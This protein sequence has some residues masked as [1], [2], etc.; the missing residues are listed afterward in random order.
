MDQAPTSGLLRGQA[1][2][3]ILS[4]VLLGLAVPLMAII[5][6][7]IIA[8]SA[9]LVRYQT[10]EIATL[11]SRGSGRAQ[12]MLLSLFEAV[13]ILLVATPAG[14]LLAKWL[15]EL[16][17]N[18]ASFL[19]LTLRAPLEADLISADWRLVGAAMLVTILARLAPTWPV[20][21]LTIV[22]QERS[23]ARQQY[24]LGAA[25]LF[26][27]G[28]L[29]LT[30]Y[31]AYRRLAQVGSLA[32]VSWKPTNVAYDPLLLLAP[33]L[34]LLVVPLVI[35]ELF[36]LLMPLLTWIGRALPSVVIYLSCLNLGREGRHYRTPVYM[37]VLCLGLG[38]FFASLARSADT[39]LVERREYEIGAD[40]TFRPRTAEVVEKASQ[41]AK[42]K[43]SALPSGGAADPELLA[44]L[45]QQPISEYERI[46]GVAGAMHVGQY[47][48]SIVIGNTY[49]PGRLLAV[50]RLRFPRV[51]YFRPDYAAEPLGQMMNRLADKR[52]ALLVPE[53]VAQRY[54][55]SEGTRVRMNIVFAAAQGGQQ[56]LQHTAEFVVVGTFRHFPTMFPQEGAVF[57]ANLDY[58]QN[59]SLETLPVGVWLRLAP[60][61]DGEAVREEVVRRAGLALEQVGDLPGLVSEDEA[62]LERVGLFGILSI[63][64]VAGAILAALGLLV[65]SA[66]AMRSRGL[67]YA[68]WQ[69][70]GLR[71]GQV[72]GI[73]LLE[74]ALTVAYSVLWGTALGIV[75]SRLYV[76]FYQFIEM[77]GAP[78]PPYN[79]LIDNERGILLAVLMAVAL[80]TVEGLVLW[81][82]VRTR[83]FEMLRIGMR[84]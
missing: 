70:L 31:Y 79:V 50:D 75:C 22:Q 62:R 44:N 30:T 14:L 58:L 74:Y 65:H 80:F 53:G 18:S 60:G 69:A 17:G 23:S 46:P 67:R 4:L 82:L 25:R 34:F 7:S 76:P 49:A 78:V 61:G 71:R 9:I 68:V 35:A 32:L 28:A 42:S 84:E 21:G 73:V 36:L 48:S 16:L 81:R 5:V 66:A 45:L 26:A 57:I 24:V 6:Y 27:V 43:E 77:K 51:A 8:V 54:D 83:V 47:K 12:I 33:A 40:L 64:F 13:V 55:L 63:S 1:R 39:W 41:T 3:D 10:Q 15:A 20:A 38:V 19:R 11:T 29:A 72:L 59:E 2:K 52:E 56:A 37:L